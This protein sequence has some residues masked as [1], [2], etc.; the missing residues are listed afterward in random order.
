MADS[1]IS[2]D[3]TG[4]RAT[5][6]RLDVTLL[7]LLTASVGAVD[8][9]SFLGLGEVFAGNMTGNVVLLAFGAAGVSELPVVKPGVALIG[10]AI[11]AALAGRVMRKRGVDRA[12]VW[13]TSVIFCLALTGLLLSIT[14]AGWVLGGP[15]SPDLLIA[16]LSAAMG[17]QGAAARQLA[18]PDLPTTVVT[19]TLTGLAADSRMAGGA[20]RRW[21]RR[22][23]ALA[24]LFAGGCS[25]ALLLRVEAPLALLPSIVLTVVVIGILWRFGLRQRGGRN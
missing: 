13:P 16:P 25:G 9:A 11:G 2:A 15:A 5:N 23:G 22:F 20:G 14:L 3:Q 6:S 21:R 24:G 12:L 1:P 4:G 7:V 19:S 18:V 10:F 17:V 8:A